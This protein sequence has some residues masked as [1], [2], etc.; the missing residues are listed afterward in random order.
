VRYDV[1]S[2]IWQTPKGNPATLF[3]R[4]STNDWNTISSIMAPHDE[5]GLAALSLAGL[6]LD[7]GSHL[8][9]CAI[10]LA[11]DNPDLRVICVE[12]VPENAELIR[13][14][15]Y[16]NGLAQRIGIVESPAGHSG[17][18]ITVRWGFAHDENA[19]H[20]AFIGNAYLL[21]PTPVEPHTE[22]DADAV[23]LPDLI[24]SAE[25]SFCKVDCEGGEYDFLDDPAVK[26]LARIHGEWHPTPKWGPGGK[27]E[28]IRLLSPTHDLT[29][30]G[31]ESGPGGFSAVRHG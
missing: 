14:N 6:A 8:G 26:Q 31:P 18:K 1:L 28:I 19:L 7:V 4:E 25:V 11:L 29:F 22:I 13:R 23:S 16:I 2:A 5:Y 24:G 17:D 30:S 3:Y 21:S 12:P 9:S 15:V 10:A 27:A 20:H